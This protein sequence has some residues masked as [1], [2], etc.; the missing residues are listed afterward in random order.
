MASP[1]AAAT[2]PQST[3]GGA[4]LPVAPDINGD[5]PRAKTAG[6]SA[7]L[8]NGG[9]RPA[10]AA[11]TAVA[12]VARSPAGSKTKTTAQQQ[13]A[14]SSASLAFPSFAPA[15]DVSPTPPGPPSGA[16]AAPLARTPNTSTSTTTAVTAA[17]S[18]PSAVPTLR[19]ALRSSAATTAPPSSP[20]TTAPYRRG[21]SRASSVFGE[22]A[23]VL[24]RRNA[25]AQA[26]LEATNQLKADITAVEE[27]VARVERELEDAQRAVAGGGSYRGKAGVALAA[28]E[29]R[30]A[31][32]ES[33]L[34]EEKR[35]LREERLVLLRSRSD[36][37]RR[38]S[39]GEKNS[40][41]NR[42]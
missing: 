26:A 25:E 22:R 13:P 19:P 24:E 8:E 31:R 4:P 5:I 39:E 11:V 6:A 23:S 37:Q 35:Q 12:D 36:Q 40:T 9:R 38:G 2:G 28:E 41:R 27:Q 42:E 21:S 29:D 15:Y 34:R 3:I 33:A 17:A 10:D 14:R 30:L 16:G 20:N 32:K 7:S 18:S 1:A